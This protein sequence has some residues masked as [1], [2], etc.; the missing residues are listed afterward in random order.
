MELFF[1]APQSIYKSFCC[2]NFY[3]LETMLKIQWI[4]QKSVLELLWITIK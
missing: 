3:V 1:I 4:P 2:L